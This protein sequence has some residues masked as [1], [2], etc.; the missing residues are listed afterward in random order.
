MACHGG[1]VRAMM[2]AA[3]AG[4]AVVL[5]AGCSQPQPEPMAAPTE[6]PTTIEPTVVVDKSAAPEPVLPPPGP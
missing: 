6:E 2:R 4:V 1:H 5:L 3:T